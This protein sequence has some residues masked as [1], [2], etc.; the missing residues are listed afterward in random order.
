MLAVFSVAVYVGLPWIFFDL[1]ERSVYGF[2]RDSL[3][4]SFVIG[5]TPEGGLETEGDLKLSDLNQMGSTAPFQLFNA[6]LNLQTDP[7]L[8]NTGRNGDFFLATRDYVGSERTGY[9]RTELLEASYSRFTAASAMAMSGAAASPHM[10]T[11]T[12]RP[13]VFVMSL[14]NIRLGCWLPNPMQLTEKPWHPNPF[15]LLREMRGHLDARGTGI[16]VS[17]GASLS[18]LKN[19]RWVA[20]RSTPTRRPIFTT[21]GIPSGR[22]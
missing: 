3:G 1:N 20:P 9:V 11:F 16:F 4:E 14:L 18:G 12:S 10:G 21:T 6:T 15:W 8:R 17:D 2:Y 22:V 19:R 5:P 7:A 13:L